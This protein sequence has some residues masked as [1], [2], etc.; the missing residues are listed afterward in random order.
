[1]LKNDEFKIFLDFFD[2]ANSNFWKRQDEVES[3]KVPSIPAKLLRKA[4]VTD[5]MGYTPDI[6]FLNEVYSEKYIDILKAF[7][8][9]NYTTFEVGIEGVLEKYYLL[10]GETIV[11]DDINYEKSTIITGNKRHNNVKY[12]VINTLQEYREFKQ[13]NPLGRFE[14]ISI[15]KEYLGR[16][17]INIQASVK[18]FYSERLIDFLLDCNITNMLVNYDNSAELDF[19]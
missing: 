2:Y 16:D 17:V 3:F 14:K 7:N 9:G 5:I 6:S 11:L 13:T 4:I 8:I 1:M 15:S 19:Y 10:F 18:P 12:H